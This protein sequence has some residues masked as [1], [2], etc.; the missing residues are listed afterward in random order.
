M[1]DS[2]TQGD[3]PVLNALREMLK[4]FS[5]NS[6]VPL[7]RAVVEHGSPYIGIDRPKGYGQRAMKQ[8]F[9]NATKLALTGRG[10]YVEG[11][12]M[13]SSGLPVHHAWVT[14]DGVHAID[15]TWANAAAHSYY[16]IQ[17]PRTVLAKWALR[18]GYFGLL[19]PWDPEIVRE[20]LTG[21]GA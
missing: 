10:T 20:A 12:A 8:C 4:V 5:R 6:D 19:V 3:H 21:M 11:F 17:F 14:L 13:S 1:I 7:W 2:V 15:A 9:V 18:R 16:G